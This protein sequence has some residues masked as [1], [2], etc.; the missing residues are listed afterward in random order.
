MANFRTLIIFDDILGYWYVSLNF[1]LALVIV[2]WFRQQ[3]PCGVEWHVRSLRKTE[4]TVVELFT[5][6]G[7]VKK[8]A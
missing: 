1:V 4:K 8:E 7:V 3:R 2:F 5:T 6:I